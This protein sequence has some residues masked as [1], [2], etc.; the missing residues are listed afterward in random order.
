MEE[1][2]KGVLKLLRD[3]TM[4]NVGQ[5]SRSEDRSLFYHYYQF[6]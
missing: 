6:I 3:M 5:N 1:I 4:M 2:G